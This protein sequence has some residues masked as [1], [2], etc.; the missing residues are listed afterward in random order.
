VSA[1]ILEAPFAS[2]DHGRRRRR[3]RGVVVTTL[4]A[5]LAFALFVLTMMVGS[6]VMSPWDVIA[7]TFHLADDPAVDFIVRELR[8][9]VATTA[10]AVG[11]ALGVSGI[12]FQT[13]LANPLASPDFVGVSSGASLFAIGAIVLFQTSGLGIP[14]AA[15]A[16]ALTSAVLIYMLAWR[17]GISGYR[18][19]LIGIAVSQFMYSIVGYVIARADIYE[20]REGMTWLVGSV[21]QAGTT[22]LR[23][24]L[25]G[26]VL[27]VPLALLLDRPL[28]VLELGD[29]TAKA[30][31]ARV[32]LTRLALLAIS[33]VLIA[34]A[35]AVAGPIMF[36]ALIAGPIARRLFGAAPGGLLAAGFAGAVIVLSA[37]L[38]AQHVMPVGLP[39]GVISGAVGAP[40][41]IWLLITVNKEGRGG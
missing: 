29:D 8:L 4:L 3:R 33:V 15:L 24:L 41:L 19:I 39:T 10:L 30:L 11:V 21:G 1:S 14:A 25:A 35:T 26:V 18:F 22:E 6:Y 40:Y 23:V 38:V 13:L 12:I 34:F 31:G 5:A 7:S 17:R 20:A 27:L 16:G 28:R 32:E 2:L 9:P 37:D 36:V